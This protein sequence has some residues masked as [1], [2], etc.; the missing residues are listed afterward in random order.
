MIKKVFCLLLLTSCFVLPQSAGNSGLAFLKLGFGSRNVA[1][2]DIGSVI[3]NDASAT[4]YN[5]AVLASNSSSEIMFMHNEWIQDVRTEV[6]GAKFSL[7]GIPLAAGINVATIGDIEVRTKPGDPISKFNADYFCGNISSGFHLVNNLDFGFS[8]KYLYEDIYID[9][10]QGYAFDFAFKYKTAIDG[11]TASAV[12][13]NLGSMTN[14]RNDGTKLPSDFRIGA[15]YSYPLSDSKFLIN[16]GTEFQKYLPT[17]DVHINVGGELVY[18]KTIALR[19]GYQSGYTAKSFTGGIG[20]VWGGLNF[21]YAFA[22]YSYD[23]GT[24]HSITLGFRF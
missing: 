24:G 23:L 21:D 1:M 17:D 10:S 20:L 15:A 12:I 5:P 2:G 18:D 9:E 4:F 7:W 11:L 8:V 3:S 14:L 22:P 13:K 16:A 6:F 19:A